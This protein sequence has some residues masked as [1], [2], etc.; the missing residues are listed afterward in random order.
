MFAP[1]RPA[2]RTQKWPPPGT[3][4]GI[5]PSPIPP[6]PP[7][8]VPSPGEIGTIIDIIHIIGKGGAVI[9][10][11]LLPCSTQGRIAPSP[12]ND[13][14]PK[15]YGEGGPY[16]QVKCDELHHLY[17]RLDDDAGDCG[18]CETIKAQSQAALDAARARRQYILHCFKQGPAPKEKCWGLLAM[19]FAYAKAAD[20][21][22]RREACF[23]GDTGDYLPPDFT[24]VRNQCDQLARSCEGVNGRY[25]D[26]LRWP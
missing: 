15:D 2:P 3:D 6:S 8:P 21:T 22:K 24:S 26:K 18:D 11:T 14:L 10:F 12:I 17:H 1:P 23:P 25:W 5:P 7:V 9:L 19:C 20:C 13:S 4:P 16:S